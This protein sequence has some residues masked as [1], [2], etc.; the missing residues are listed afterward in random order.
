M[1]F[2]FAK[3]QSQ[4]VTLL[5]LLLLIFTWKMSQATES[6]F[7][8]RMQKLKCL[9]KAK[10][11]GMADQSNI[12][13]IYRHSRVTVNCVPWWFFPPPNEEIATLPCLGNLLGCLKTQSFLILL[14]FSFGK[15]VLPASAPFFGR[16]LLPL[17]ILPCFREDITAAADMVCKKSCSQWAKENMF[18]KSC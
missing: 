18:L 1:V 2:G 5:L 10:P 15:C 6:V 7:F 11:N 8:L 14:F 12:F 13:V 17:F 16:D 3:L 9:W 4:F